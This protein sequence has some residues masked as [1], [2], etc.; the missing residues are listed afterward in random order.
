MSGKPGKSGGARQGSG[1]KP[2]PPAL[3]DVPSTEKPLDFLLAV[4]ND[5]SVDAKLRVRAAVAAAQYVHVKRH[6]GGQKDE[7]D[8]A[9]SRAAQGK[10]SASEPPKL[11]VSNP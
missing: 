5:A 2:R 8:R 11:V 6:D 1:P 9:A 7:R 10:Y 4:M 3:L